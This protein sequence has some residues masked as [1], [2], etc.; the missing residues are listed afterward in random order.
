MPL[1]IFKIFYVVAGGGEQQHP[2]LEARKHRRDRLHERFH[3]GDV[4]GRV[5]D[6]EG[7][8]RKHLDPGGQVGPCE[9]A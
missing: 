3:R 9:A 6:D 5:D 8:P 7:P 4:V 2:R 1:Y